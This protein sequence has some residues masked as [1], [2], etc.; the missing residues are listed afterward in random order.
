MMSEMEAINEPAHTYL[1]RIPAPKWLRVFAPLPKFKQTTSNTAESFNSWLGNTR[2]L[3]HFKIISSLIGKI[4][5]F[6]FEKKQGSCKW[7][8]SLF[9]QFVIN[10]SDTPLKAVEWIVSSMPPQ[11]LSSR[12][13][14]P[15]RKSTL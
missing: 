15:P 14:Q 8:E 1:A 4:A 10:G 12:Q 3:S 13:R 5:S 9:L 7:K 11:S 6:F 2:D